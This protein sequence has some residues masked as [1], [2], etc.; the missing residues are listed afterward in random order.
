MKDSFIVGADIG[1]SHITVAL[2]DINSKSVIKDSVERAHVRSGGSIENIIEDWCRVLEKVIVGSGLQNAHIGI[3]MPGPFQYEEGISYIKGLSKYESLYNQNVRKLIARKLRMVPE[4]IK[5]K[6]DAGCF[7]QGEALGGAAAGYHHAIGFTLGTGIGTAKY[8]NGIGED[9]DLWKLP[10]KNSVAEEY[11]ATRWFTGRYHELTAKNVSDV[12]ELVALA[13]TDQ[14]VSVVFDEFAD[15]LAGFLTR[16]VAMENPDIIVM[17]GNVSKASDYFLPRVL[18]LL[19]NQSINIP[20]KK[21]MLGE[22][23]AI[24]GAAWCRKARLA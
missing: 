24:L 21:A 9:A 4:A 10:F 3:A 19:R 2:V 8:H 7:L 14:V 13:S 16:F 6:N 20:L 17:G 23:A 11:L 1:G 22:E 5:F 18:D 12:K 15:N